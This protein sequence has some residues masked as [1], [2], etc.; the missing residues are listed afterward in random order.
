LL[1]GT[2][3]RVTE[4][5]PLFLDHTLA[6][7]DAHVALEVA[8]RRRL[9]DLVEVEIEPRC[10][11]RFSGPGGAPAFV[12][13]D[14]YVVS[15][16]DDFEDCWFIEIDRG[17]ESPAAISRKCRAYDLYWRSGL[18]QAEHDTYPLVLWVAPDDRR[19][20]HIERVVKGARN[21]NRELFRCTIAARLVETIA[22]GAA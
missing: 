5:S 3:T 13:P 2:R 8:S 4:P 9:F 19:A 17:T 7:A 6:I 18:E 10:W 21:V 14:L 16:R 12:K 22:G 15:G 1:A 20:H 11:R